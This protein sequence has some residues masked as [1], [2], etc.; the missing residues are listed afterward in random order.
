MEEA[1]IGFVVLVAGVVI[2]SLFKPNEAQTA[3]LY[4]DDIK[5]PGSAHSD[6]HGHGHHH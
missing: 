2:G 5:G 6:D 4:P 1:I 3:P